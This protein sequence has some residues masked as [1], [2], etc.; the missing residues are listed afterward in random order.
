MGT[1]P[2]GASAGDR[3]TDCCS[4]LTM[5]SMLA[6]FDLLSLLNTTKYILIMIR[7]TVVFRII[8]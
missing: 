1:R 8:F 2:H 4:L 5:Q 7:N 3:E 6:L